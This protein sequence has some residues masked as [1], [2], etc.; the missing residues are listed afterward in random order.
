[1]DF[2]IP[3]PTTP[4][5]VMYDGAEDSTDNLHNALAKKYAKQASSYRLGWGD[6]FILIGDLY[7]KTSTYCG[8]DPL[9]KKAGYWA[10]I[11]KYEYAR[12][13]DSKSSNSANQKIELYKS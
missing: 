13:I 2:G 3:R 6:P 1:M 9:S 8:N 4:N 11:E 5:T 10:A 12:L 7:S